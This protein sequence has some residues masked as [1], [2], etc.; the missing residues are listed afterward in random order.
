MIYTKLYLDELDGEAALIIEASQKED[1]IYCYHAKKLYDKSG[2]LRFYDPHT[3]IS[4][5]GVAISPE[6]KAFFAARLDDP[7]YCQTTTESG[8]FSLVADERTSYGGRERGYFAF[9]PDSETFPFRR[10]LTAS[11]RFLLG[12]NGGFSKSALDEMYEVNNEALKH[13]DLTTPISKENLP[14]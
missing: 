13:L 8:D 3:T 10:V 6:A 4:L 7:D 11:E 2:R 14:Q 5:A 1:G 9:R 12:I